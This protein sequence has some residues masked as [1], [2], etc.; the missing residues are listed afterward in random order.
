MLGLWQAP[1]TGLREATASK[2]QDREKPHDMKMTMEII[3]KKWVHILHM[4]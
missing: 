4:E 1:E 2:R 3:V